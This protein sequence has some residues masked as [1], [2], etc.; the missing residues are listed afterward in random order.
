MKYT[1]PYILVDFSDKKLWNSTNINTNWESN[2]RIDN[3]FVL[4]YTIALN[5]FLIPGRLIKYIEISY[6]SLWFK[7]TM[8]LKLLKFFRIFMHFKHCLAKNLF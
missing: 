4:K 6:I 7:Y 3:Y 2:E 8:I 5:I 1:R